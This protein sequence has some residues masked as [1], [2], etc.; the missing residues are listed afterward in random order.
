MLIIDY[1][2]FLLQFSKKTFSY[3]RTV[4]TGILILLI[5]N[6][7]YPG[8]T[9]YRAH[10]TRLKM[11]LWAKDS[12]RSAAKES[13]INGRRVEHIKL[14]QK[15]QGSSAQ[16]A[17]LKLRTFTFLT[18]YCCIDILSYNGMTKRQIWIYQI[19][20]CQVEH[21]KLPQ[22]CPVLSVQ[23]L[24]LGHLIVF[25]FHCYKTEWRKNK[26]LNKNR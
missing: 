8:V 17:S 26:S 12:P 25:S 18:C 4:F 5:T 23:A 16:C 14:T 24:K 10:K 2:I 1:F 13:W 6:L 20:S 3:V 22:K 21:I 11:S 19:D 7:G 9:Q 15:G